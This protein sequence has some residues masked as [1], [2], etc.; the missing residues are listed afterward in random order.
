MDVETIVVTVV[1]AVSGLV[2][3]WLAGKFD[4]LRAK[5]EA[6]ENKIDD[7]LLEVFD[8]LVER[9]NANKASNE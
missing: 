1:A 4:V 8:K 3:G 9:L 6:S 5:V 7:A 2:V